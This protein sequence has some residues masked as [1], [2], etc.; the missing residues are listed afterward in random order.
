[1]KIALLYP[2]WTEEYGKISHFAKK[3][4]KWPPLNLAYLA[5]IA[6]KQGHE[7]IIIDGEAEGLSIEEIVKQTKEFNPDII[8]CTGTTPFYHI[9]VEM[10]NA[11]KKE[12]NVPIVIGGPHITVL[13]GE[14]FEDCFD[15][16]FIGEGDNSWPEFLEKYEKKEDV[17]KIRGMMHRD[18]G[19]IKFTG[20]A[21]P[22]HDMDSVP[23]PARHLLKADKYNLGTSK[24]MQKFTTIMTVR[25]C[26][27]K[28]I[29]CSTKVFGNDT[30][31]KN[32]ELVIEEMKECIEKQGVEH[33]MFLDDTLTMNREHMMKICELMIKENLGVTF[34]GSTR[35]NLIDEELIKIMVDAGLIRLSFGLESVDETIRTTMKKM[36][37][38]ESY[39]TANKL[40]NKYD[41]ETLNSCMIGL[42]GETR[43][44]V[45]K[46]LKFLR[47]SKDI[48]QA[49]ISIAVPYPG[50][51][52]F[53]MAKKGENGLKLETEDF[54]NYRRYNAAVMTV[55]DLSPEDLVEIQNEAFASIYLAPWRWKPMINKSGKVGALLTFNRLV[56]ALKKGDTEFITNSQLGVVEKN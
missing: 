26:P 50:T 49:N 51:E 19:E 12:L 43:E 20:Q 17:T 16:A 31:M 54:S 39:I 10:A 23:S 46:T 35:A 30:R 14:V 21:F 6:E 28:C 40:T 44:T 33:F 8:G 11:L 1:M 25:G 52:L 3:A 38:L 4:G 41:I 7:V 45:K 48:K 2:L 36:V 42:P 13:K 24:G 27:F 47:E 5:A 32:P 55:G 15:Y 9:V 56:K 34:E 22:I 29:F 37:P 18:N 53:E